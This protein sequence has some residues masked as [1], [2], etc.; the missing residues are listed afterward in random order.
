[1][2]PDPGEDVASGVGRMRT[3]KAKR[4]ASQPG[5][6]TLSRMMTVIGMF[7][8]AIFLAAA[9]TPFANVLGSWT[10]VR[11]ELG[12]ADA[13]VVLGAGGPTPP[14]ILDGSSSRK[15]LYGIRLYHNGLAPL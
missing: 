4:P 14:G 7:A 5:P 11:G 1:M 8:V 9:F 3:G 13:I 2:L 6:G 15:T 12:P 10:S